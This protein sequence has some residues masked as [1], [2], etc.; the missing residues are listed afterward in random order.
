MASS[1]KTTG[2]Y[3]LTFA[4]LDARVGHEPL[5]HETGVKMGAHSAPSPDEYRD[6]REIPSAPAGA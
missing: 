2:V 5:P 3:Y 6:L 4:E 1:I